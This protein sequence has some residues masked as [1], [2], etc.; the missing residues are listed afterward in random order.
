MKLSFWEE[1]RP[2]GAIQGTELEAVVDELCD[3]KQPLLLSTP[4]L[5]YESRFLERNGG[6]VKIRA[7]MNRD[8]ARHGLGQHP[9]RLRFAWAL[10][11]YSGPT[12]ILDYIQEENQRFL[13]IDLPGQLILDEQRRAFRVDQV[14]HSSGAL[15][16]P[17]GTI[18]K[19]SLENISTLGASIFCIEAI[20]AE[21][22]QMG[23][24][25]ALSL[26]LDKGFDF[27]CGAK[28]RHSDGQTLGLVFD[29]PLAGLPLQRLEEWIAPRKEEAFRRWQNRAEL[30]ARAERQVRPKA[31]P[32]GALLLSS[33]AEL[34][35]QITMVLEGEL[36]VRTVP[37]AVAPFKEA[38]AEPPLI[39]LVDALNEGV[40]GRYR[41]RTIVESMPVK[42]PVVV[43]G[44]SET[45]ESAMILARELKEA[46][47]LEWKPEHGVFLRRM[48]K[49]LVQGYGKDV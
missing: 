14:G 17:D 41:L 3:R 29:P 24:P 1:S 48:L 46:I 32:S 21:R 2:S 30:R 19:I 47:F 23:R 9:L 37:P 28:I 35:A 6:Q 16:S 15:G 31:Q 26:S 20:P 27:T 10:T 12:R 11:F 40:E 4:Y 49:M 44:S 42:A 34:K 5:H 39:L 45:P 36:A 33:R 13:V 43:L 8:A 18:L 25:L 38:L 7:T 22:F